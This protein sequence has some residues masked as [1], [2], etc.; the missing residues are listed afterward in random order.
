MSVPSV[1]VVTVTRNARRALEGTIASVLSQT[2]RPL[3]YLVIDGA[4]TDGTVD[5]LAG[6]GERLRW[7]SEPDD[8]VYDAMNR[9]L[10]RIGGPDA[11]VFFLNAD[12]RFVSP[13]AVA[14]VMA[15]AGGAEFVHGLLE[16]RDDEL[17]DRGIV[18]G[19]VGLR[20]LQFGNRCGQQMIFCRRAVFDKIG[21]FDLDYPIAADYDW[22]IRVFQDRTVSIRFVP[23][24]AAS[25]GAGG[26]SQRH[27]AK[28]L[29]ECRRIVRRRFGKVASA[30]YALHIAA[31]EVP[32]LVARRALRGLGLLK[33]ARALARALRA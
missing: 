9:A 23:E 31:V 17:D 25:M 12:D 3:D 24:V 28:V 6:F 1:T 29:Q 33:P 27:Y 22:V 18:G 7:V 30:R 13:D 20:D 10:A 8:G 11:Y 16:V 21:A 15:G 32:R 14:R 4:S 19:R 2:Y 5:L 26:L